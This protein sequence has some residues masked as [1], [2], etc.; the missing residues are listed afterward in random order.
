MDMKAELLDYGFPDRIRRAAPLL[1]INTVEDLVNKLRSE[2]VDGLFTEG[3]RGITVGETLGVLLLNGVSVEE[4]L[5]AYMGDAFSP[6]TKDGF[7]DEKI[8]L[9][10]AVYNKVCSGAN[11]KKYTHGVA[12]YPVLM[13]E[14]EYRNFL[15]LKQRIVSYQFPKT[16]NPRDKRMAE[17]LELLEISCASELL[18]MSLGDILT[19]LNDRQIKDTIDVLSEFLFTRREGFTDL[20]RLI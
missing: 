9:F 7:W 12:T 2:G 16:S 1:G 13:T 18:D 10:I 17:A 11:H 8:R 5:E 15:K 20:V 4:E 3:C 6:D 19:I 14:H